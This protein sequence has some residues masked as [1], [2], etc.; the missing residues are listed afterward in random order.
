MLELACHEMDRRDVH[1]RRTSSLYE[2]RPMYY[3]DQHSFL[4]G[5]CEVSRARN[6]PELR[7]LV[8]ADPRVFI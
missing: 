1:V 5:A 8:I 3:H 4:N 6:M 2:T 7:H